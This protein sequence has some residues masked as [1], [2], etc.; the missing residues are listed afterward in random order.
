MN[1]YEFFPISGLLIYSVGM[2]QIFFGEFNCALKSYFH[3]LENLENVIVGIFDFY[4]FEFISLFKIAIA[5]FF[6]FN[7]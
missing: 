4:N 3:A 5:I 2:M 1:Y 7:N 6:W